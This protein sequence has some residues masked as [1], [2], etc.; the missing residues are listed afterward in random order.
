MEKHGWTHA[1]VHVK[2]YDFH[3]DIAMN[4][5]I[6][7]IYVQSK[8]I[9]DPMCD[10][11]AFLYSGEKKR[12]T[13]MALSK[14]TCSINDVCIG[15]RVVVGCWLLIQRARK[16]SVCNMEKGT[17]HVS[18]EV[19]GRYGGDYCYDALPMVWWFEWTENID[20]ICKMCNVSGYELG[21]DFC[22]PTSS[23]KTLSC[24]TFLFLIAISTYIGHLYVCAVCVLT[25]V[26]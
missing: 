23:T 14:E 13:A 6:R 19:C 24:S 18:I 1:L 21:V 22:R 25:Y 17:Q 5:L 8:P 12:T 15:R 7:I 4:E 9:F 3:F 20:K 11:F 10:D 2:L 26:T 16:L